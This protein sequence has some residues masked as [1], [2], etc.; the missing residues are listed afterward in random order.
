[1]P[2]L[3]PWTPPKLVRPI[4]A[5][6]F[7]ALAV[8]IDIGTKAIAMNDKNVAQGCESGC[9]PKTKPGI[10][11]MAATLYQYI[12]L[13][14]LPWSEI[15]PLPPGMEPPV[16]VNDRA[17]HYTFRF[18]KAKLMDVLTQATPPEVLAELGDISP[19]YS[20][21]PAGGAMWWASALA[22]TGGALWFLAKRNLFVAAG[23]TVLPVAVTLA[24]WVAVT[25]YAASVALI[26]P[27]V[28]EGAKW[29]FK[30]GVLPLVKP[31]ANAVAW[32]IGIG[33]LAV[34]GA[35]I[36]KYTRPKQ[37]AVEASVAA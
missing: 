26:L 33:G 37:Q 27:A 29:I 2:N 5:Q 15:G 8:A 22:A 23:S 17:S 9:M 13:E 1:M 3:P 6:A 14:A 32:V 4:T 10:G 24:R 16:D 11:T 21:E 36:Y 35:L 28:P 12:P 19:A 7:A 30:E 25:C 34:V 31:A 18:G 20:D